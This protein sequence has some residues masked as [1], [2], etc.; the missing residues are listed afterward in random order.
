MKNGKIK[1]N[2][3]RIIALILLLCTVTLMFSSCG[4]EKIEKPEDTNLEYWLLDKPNKKEW[5]KLRSDY[6]L[7]AKYEP[8]FDE[9][10]K[11]SAP[12]H[13][14]IYY[15]D[16]YPISE[17]G[18]KRIDGIVITDPNVYVWGLTINST[19]EEALEVLSEL[20]FSVESGDNSCSGEMGQYRIR[21]TYGESLW[22]SYRK[23]SIVNT[24]IFGEKAY[25]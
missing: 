15:I 12:E 20:G 1:T 10:G 3:T 21:L 11:A 16:N 18:L 5:T 7:A 4:S 25:R 23:F 22:I 8:V 6:Y 17:I 9:D 13:A 19:K 14:V 24:I 2:K